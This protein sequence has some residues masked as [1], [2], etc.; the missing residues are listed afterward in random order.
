MQAALEQLPRPILDKLRSIIARVRCLLLIRGIFATLAIALV[1][2]LVIMAIDA[3]ITIFSETLRLGMSLA[4]LAVTLI[5]AWWYL[6]RPLSHRYSLT[7]VARILEIRH[8]ELQ[9]RISTAVE[10]MSSKDT[11]SIRGS[12]E[13]IEAV[14]D[15][16]VV[17][18]E[19]VD[20]RAE[21]RGTSTRRFVGLAAICLA[22][23][24]LVLLLFPNQGWKLLARAA[25]PFLDIGNAYADTMR[26]QPGDIRIL[27]GDELT[28]EMTVRHDRLRRAELRRTLPD[29]SESV[30]RMA[31]LGD[32]EDGAKVFALTFPAVDE[33]FAYRVRA[34]AA[35]SEFF[36]VEAVPPPVVESRTIRCEFPAYTG[37]PPRESESDGEIR[38]VAHTEI[39]VISVMNKPARTARAILNERRELGRTT[40]DAATGTTRLP[41]DP[42]ANGVWH[43]EVED[44][45]GF[46]T[47]P[48]THP[49]QALPDKAPSVRITNP[50]ARELRLKP[51]EWLPLAYEIDE[52]FGFGQVDLLVTPNG[53]ATPRVL[54]QPTP[55]AG[56]GPGSWRGTAPLNLA[57]LDL[58]P[59]HH[60]LR[61][62]LR[63]R[64]NRPV[65]LEGPG[66]G[67]SETLTV[68]LDRSA[69]SLAEQTIRAQEEQINQA[70][71]EAE[72]DLRRAREEIRNA[73]RELARQ[74]EM[75]SRAENELEDFDSRAERAAEN[76]REIAEQ[77]ENSVFR[78]Q[79]DA[80]GDIAEEEVARARESA[81]LIPI[82]DGNDERV[83]QAGEA[84]EQIEQA[85][86]GVEEVKE[87]IREKSEDLKRIAGL[88]ELA[89]D[90]RELA[91]DAA[92]EAAM[93]ELDAASPSDESRQ[94][95][96]ERREEE[97][98]NQFQQRQQ[99][100][101]QKLGELL[102]DDPA[103]L[104]EILEERRDTAEALAE[105]A[106]QLAAEQ[107]ELR[108]L[109]RAT[110]SSE[111]S[112][113]EEPLREALLEQLR[114]RQKQIAAETQNLA[115]AN[116][117]AEAA[118]EDA[119]ASRSA[120]P[121]SPPEA[122]E[123]PG[124]TPALAEAGEQ[125]RSA[126]ESLDE[127][128]LASATKDAR[129]ASA[130]L[131]R[132]ATEAASSETGEL[133]S[134]PE[135]GEGGTPEPAAESLTELAERQEALANQ[136]AAIGAGDLPAALALLEET[137]SAEAASLQAEAAGLERSLQ[138]LDERQSRYEAGHAANFLRSASQQAEQASRNLSR[139]Q[140][141]QE[142]AE[143]Q[144]LVEPGEVA[145]QS[146]AALTQSDPVQSSA[147]RSLETAADSLSKS[148]R[149]LE[150]TLRG[151]E[152]SADEEG[153]ADSAAMAE[154]FEDVSA[155]ARSATPGQAAR[156]SEQAARSLQQ[157]AEQS[158]R[159]LGDM[160]GAPP[161]SLPG[162][163]PPRPDDAFPDGGN[164]PNEGGKTADIISEAIPPEL[165]ELGISA[166]DWAR[167]RGTLTGGSATAIETN[168]PAEYRELVGRYFQVIAREAGAKDAT[169]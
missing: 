66:E 164:L 134:P 72:S 31:F 91:R 46:K 59:S 8:P 14:V 151:L 118:S 128:E 131:R 77:L 145:P 168:L 104:G 87:A 146:R 19:A 105:R 47:E 108:N 153:I 30:E 81:D 49:I 27:R 140:E 116:Q 160:G 129:A 80:L 158:M 107:E 76:L 57:S 70:I 69:P 103:A 144:G 15:S 88:N 61:I 17:D 133:S 36:E 90:Q 18:V 33:D 163:A 114:E 52:D 122:A 127:G 123:E 28:I 79:A 2:L 43:L 169:P 16:A 20:P 121:D 136:L 101:Q 159:Q 82:T 157:L 62:Q 162:N 34:G 73:Q 75:T 113:R 100:V 29:G 68:R 147:R 138:S 166:K 132:A 40:G 85:L 137:I 117:A 97:T 135:R 67:L 74:E 41:L 125:T 120:Q 65:S 9:E 143:A 32:T 84:G 12:Q 6:L 155:S 165:E 58:E 99:Q 126:A 26:V 110:A 7:Q 3:S 22:L 48:G 11:D 10:L 111:P 5:A 102:Q 112:D 1:C 35:L 56:E 115:A 124:I 25:A 44:R 64:D 4:A 94:T 60:T 149:Q 109:T 150:G 139:A 142:Q 23:L 78:Q 98:M 92:E 39:T 148:A 141:S 93:A 96:R 152:A 55:L 89:N 167:F 24:S 42:T 154:G 50:P 63:A 156:R 71:R 45:D 161:D 21:F 38:A 51:T 130:S 13:L 86:A 37:L 106:R 83:A 119:A 95:G 53:E 54:A